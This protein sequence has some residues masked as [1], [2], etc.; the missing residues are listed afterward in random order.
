[1]EERD[2]R[3]D[4][5]SELETKRH[6]NEDEGDRHREDD[7]AGLRRYLL[8]FGPTM[9]IRSNTTPP[10]PYFWRKAV[11]MASITRLLSFQGRASGG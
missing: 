5:E 2:D 1:V 3:G 7:V 4:P 10:S 11:L 9:S 6:V 8:I